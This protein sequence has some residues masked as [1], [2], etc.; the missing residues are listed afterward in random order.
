MTISMAKTLIY[1]FTLLDFK[2]IVREVQLLSE[3]LTDYMKT[4]RKITG[5]GAGESEDRCQESEVRDRITAIN[6][7]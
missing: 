3:M 1:R 6:D 7:E 4:A 2:T 5:T